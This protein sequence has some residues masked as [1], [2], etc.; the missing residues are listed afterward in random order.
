MLYNRVIPVLLLKNDHLV[1]TIQF[2]KEVYVGDPVNAVKIYNEKEVD[3]IVILDITASQ[4]KREPNFQLI[5]EIASECFMPL[6]YGG[7]IKTVEH[8]RKLFECGVEKVSIN[9]AAIENSTII[10]ELV[11]EFGSQSIVVSIDVE[12]RLFKGKTLRKN[13]SISNK[14][15]ISIVDFAK[16]VESKGCGEIFL[17][18]VYE[19]GMRNGYDLELIKAVTSNADI[20]VIC[21]G[22]AGSFEDF[23]QALKSGASAVAAGSKFV[24]HGKH[25]AVL[26]TYLSPDEIEA[27]NK[28]D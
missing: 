25:R 8:A 1:K 9:S 20:P 3:E 7:G 11:E 21:C 6:C 5:K 17:N 18:A 22:G 14:K 26:I 27:I 19:D 10:E 2:K 12:K 13:K 23:K 15:E 16:H 4:E 28:N 24:L